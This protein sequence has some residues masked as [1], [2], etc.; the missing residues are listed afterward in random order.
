[1]PD[2]DSPCFT[3]LASG[4]VCGHRYGRHFGPRAVSGADVEWRGVGV[5]VPAV[6]LE[7]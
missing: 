1:M 4:A 7:G 5:P 6:H 3:V 2:A